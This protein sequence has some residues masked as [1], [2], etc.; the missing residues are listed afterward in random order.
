MPQDEQVY[1][2]TYKDANGN[3]LQTATFNAHGIGQMFQY[4]LTV[5][6]LAWPAGATHVTI[7]IVQCR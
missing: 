2:V 4:M 6:S 7:E 5:A 1:R 3:T